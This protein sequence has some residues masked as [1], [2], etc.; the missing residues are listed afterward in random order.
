MKRYTSHLVVPGPLNHL[1]SSLVN[2]EVPHLTVEYCTLYI[3]RSACHPK[4]PKS[5]RRGDGGNEKHAGGL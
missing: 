4:Q 3:L 2:S 1:S 5:G